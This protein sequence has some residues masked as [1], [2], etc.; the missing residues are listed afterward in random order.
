MRRY[1]PPLVIDQSEGTPNQDRSIAVRRNG[2][3]I[4]AGSFPSEREPNLES[5]EHPLEEI[6]LLLLAHQHVFHQVFERFR[7]RLLPGLG[8]DVV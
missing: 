5:P 6:D 3:F 2:Y 1:H 8:D 7:A 4:H